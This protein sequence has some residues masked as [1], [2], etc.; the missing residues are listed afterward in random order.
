MHVT[1]CHAPAKNGS[2]DGFQPVGDILS[3]MDFAILE[4]DIAS[5]KPVK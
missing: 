2:A 5:R 1:L 4:N 3:N